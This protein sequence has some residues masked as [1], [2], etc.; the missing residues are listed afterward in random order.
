MG[1]NPVYES[2]RHH[3]G[4]CFGPQHE[5]DVRYQRKHHHQPPSGAGRD[6]AERRSNGPHGCRRSPRRERRDREYGIVGCDWGNRGNWDAR[7][8]RRNGFYRGCG[9]CG[10]NRWDR[11]NRSHRKYRCNRQQ[12]HQRCKR[13]DRCHRKRRCRRGNWGNRDARYPRRNWIYGGCGCNRCNRC[14]GNN[15][16]YR[17]YRCNRQQRCDRGNRC[18]WHLRLQW[19]RWCRCFP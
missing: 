15:R 16:S 7:Y 6:S 4:G 2:G 5:R 14:H 10:C 18:N 13:S 1:N 8:P 19:H 17:K 9:Y 11:N 12:R 3:Q